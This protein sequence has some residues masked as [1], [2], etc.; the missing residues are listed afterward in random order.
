MKTLKIAML[1]TFVALAMVSLANADGFKVD[2]QKKVVN[3]S[4]AQAESN[5]GL[6]IEMYRQLNPSMLNNNALT[7]TVYVVYNNTCYRISGTYEQWLR[8]FHQRRSVKENSPKFGAGV[9]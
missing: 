7:Y 1:A 4:L 8:F 3:I 5:P 9:E 2:P 6:I